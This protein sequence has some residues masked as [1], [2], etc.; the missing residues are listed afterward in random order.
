LQPPSNY[1]GPAKLFGLTMDPVTGQEIASGL[2]LIRHIND[3]SEWMPDRH[4]KEH[5]PGP[6]PQSVK[7]AIK[8]FI[9][10]CAARQVRGQAHKHNSM[11]L[12]V[13]RYTA[14]QSCVAD[15]VREELSFLQ[16][17]LRYGDGHASVR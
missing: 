2:P 11:L 10:T 14:V 6:L 8:A 9:L 15:Q 7:Q 17:R 3:F 12:H 4:K 16:Q 5:R 13:T 1:L